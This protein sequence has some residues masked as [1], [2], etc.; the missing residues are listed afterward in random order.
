MALHWPGF[1]ISICDPI[2]LSC[3]L[4]LDGDD[5]EMMQIRRGCIDFIS[6]LEYARGDILVEYVFY[7]ESIDSN[8]RSPKIRSHRL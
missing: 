2:G 7:S 1:G 3:F 5:D 4:F 6:L 8:F